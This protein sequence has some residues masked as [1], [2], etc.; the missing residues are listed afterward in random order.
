M[1]EAK[2]EQEGEESIIAE[3]VTHSFRDHIVFFVV[4]VLDEIYF[5]PNI[6][7]RNLSFEEHETNQG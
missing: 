2:S 3:A 4:E 1:L 5:M 7:D 6:S